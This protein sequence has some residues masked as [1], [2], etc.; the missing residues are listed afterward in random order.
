MKEKKI[1]LISSI[2]TLVLFVAHFA[3]LDDRAW[4]ITK[5]LTTDQKTKDQSIWLPDYQVTAT[6]TIPGIAQN[7]SG[8]THSS[9]SNT[10]WVVVNNPTYRIKTYTYTY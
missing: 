2:I 10:L 4:Q 8:I 3:D 6:A 9:K 7:A 1:I 5:D